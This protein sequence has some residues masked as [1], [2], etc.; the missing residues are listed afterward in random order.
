MLFRDF[1][2]NAWKDS[3]SNGD[4]AEQQVAAKEVTA[5]TMQDKEETVLS[6]GQ[7]HPDSASASQD[8]TVL[9]NPATASAPS[10][11]T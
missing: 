11:W 3:R 4:F 2:R 6:G 7:S 9:P 1:L 10:R 8:A 5:Q